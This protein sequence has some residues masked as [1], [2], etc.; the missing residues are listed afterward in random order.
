MFV[1][2][3]KAIDDLCDLMWSMYTSPDSVEKLQAI[4]EHRR[5]FHSGISDMVYLQRL[6]DTNRHRVADMS[7]I[8]P[9]DS[10]WDANVHME[11]GFEMD[12]GRKRIQ[13]DNYLPYCTHKATGKRIRFKSLH[14][15]GARGKPHIRAAWDQSYHDPALRKAA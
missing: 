15:Q 11:E 4:Y 2:S 10:Y 12:S 9:D 7:G 13:F 8:Q 5:K 14:F 6:Y 3:I 1:N